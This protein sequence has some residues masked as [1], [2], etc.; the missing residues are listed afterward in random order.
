M[1]R[2][3]NMHVSAFLNIFPRKVLYRMFLTFV[4]RPGCDSTAV[5]FTTSY[6]ISTYHH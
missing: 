5:R 2:L 6:A 1:R 3:F 4:I